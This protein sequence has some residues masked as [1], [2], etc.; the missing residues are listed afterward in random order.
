[1]DRSPEVALALSLVLLLR[2]SGPFFSF[3]KSSGSF[4][5]LSGWP[6]VSWFLWDCFCGE[7]WLW[8]SAPLCSGHCLSAGSLAVTFWRSTVLSSLSLDNLVFGLFE[9]ASQT[10]LFTGYPQFIR[11]CVVSTF[12]ATVRHVSATPSIH[13]DLC[14]VVV[15]SRAGCQRLD[16][17][18]GGIDNMWRQTFH[19]ELP[20]GKENPSFLCLDIVRSWQWRFENAE[21]VDLCQFTAQNYVKLPA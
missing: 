21:V 1:M 8:S 17:H 9:S 7:V 12:A 13:V 20:R 16:V 15:K 4:F 3:R 14:H 10:R 6:L 2:L 5:V 19:R 11:V 18:T